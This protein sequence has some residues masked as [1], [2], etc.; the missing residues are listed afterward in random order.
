MT[1]EKPHIL[2]VESEDD[3]F[4]SQVPF[5]FLGINKVLYAFILVGY[6]LLEVLHNAGTV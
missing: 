6:S 2:W 3:R 4:I 1:W 5:Q